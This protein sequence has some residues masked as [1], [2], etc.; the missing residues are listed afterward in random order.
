MQTEILNAIKKMPVEDQIE[1]V[2]DIWNNISENNNAVGLTERQVEI[3]KNRYQQFKADSMTAK[4]W[5]EI[6]KDFEQ[7]K[8]F[9]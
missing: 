1:L 3:L 5:D 6:K 7:K 4:N 2:E 8:N 9:K